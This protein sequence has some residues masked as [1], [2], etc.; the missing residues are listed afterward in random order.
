MRSKPPSTRI[1][2]DVVIV[3]SGGVVQAVRS[4]KDTRLS[5]LVL[6]FD[7]EDDDATWREE[8]AVYLDLDF[9]VN[10]DLYPVEEL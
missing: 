4:R 2:A 6:D 7:N 9:A 8:H 1:L 5:F 3:V 10:R